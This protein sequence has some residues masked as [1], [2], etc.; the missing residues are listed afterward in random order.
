MRYHLE[1]RATQRWKGWLEAPVQVD[2]ALNYLTLDLTDHHGGGRGG[3]TTRREVSGVRRREGVKNEVGS[4]QLP[5][6]LT[7]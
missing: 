7:G 6:E 1:C 4:L 2:A 5:I 3:T